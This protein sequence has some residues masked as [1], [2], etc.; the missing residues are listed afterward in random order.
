[1]NGR[2]LFVIGTTALAAL[3]LFSTDHRMHAAEPP[4]Q[5]EQPSAS[6]SAAEP[7]VIPNC[8]LALIMKEDV[9]SQQNGVLKFIGRE[10][11]EGEQFP[12]EEIVDTWQGK[13][14]R[15][16]R[17][18][19]RVE[20][21]QLL[22]V[23]DD[24]LPR[25][26]L[27]IKIAKLAAAK[28][29]HTSSEK[30]RDE[31]EK[32]YDTARKLYGDKGLGAISLED[33]RQAQLAWD[34]Y[35]YEVVSKKEAIN[36]ADQEKNQAQKTLEMFEVRSKIPGIVKTIYKYTGEGVSSTNAGKNADPI[37]LIQ[38]YDRLRAEG[39]VEV[40]YANDIHEGMDVVLE[41]TYRDSPE[42]TYNGH[43]LEVTGVAVSK[44][45]KLPLIV[46]CSEDGTAIVW[47]RGN[48]RPRNIFLHKDSYGNAVPVRCVA[49]TPP[50]SEANLAITGAT[51]GKARIWDLD[52]PADKPARELAGTHRGPIRCVAFSSDGKLC[53][54]G[55][56]D[57]DII[58]SDTASGQVRYHIPSQRDV[59]GHRNVVTSLFITPGMQMVSAGRDDT[60]R[61]WK[62]GAEGAEQ[63]QIIR[64]RGHEEDV[65]G[66]SHDGKWLLDEQGNEMRV[67]SLNNQMTEAILR[68]QAPSSK[69]SRFALF[70]P[71]GQL[72]LTSSTNDGVLQL[73]RLGRQRSHEVRQL[74]PGVRSEATCA[75]FSPDGSFIV[76]G[77]RDRKVF[78]WPV[79]SEEDIN[80]Q[81]VAHVTNIEKTVDSSES[82]VRL[83]AE[84][85][86]GGKRPLR[87]G[88]Q[89]TMVAFPARRSAAVTQK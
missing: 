48:A 66:V 10:V 9:P 16:L 63:E 87:P 25:A 67:L 14:F 32:R 22:A 84:F 73:W 42:D 47:E 76:G 17:E 5:A 34:H 35:R 37:V 54:T 8:R 36:V 75:A 43:R 80:Q 57:S 13:R 11:K 7:I 20:A 26:D 46:S 74:M 60:I 38:N 30:S 88:E 2:S 39:L 62:L 71:N 68:N 50:G 6:V 81:I 58:L 53:A 85:V 61:V 41:P 29:D 82:Q 21:N 44:D 51:D 72:A 45:P 49:C 4:A 83:M 77:I 78:V 56:E 31:T 69:F 24:T 19:D 1:M 33:V 15:R 89:V 18:G 40:Q 52:A 55:G 86:N 3:S 12:P 79:P 70:S 28:A 59:G 65:L 64:R 23:V 27:A